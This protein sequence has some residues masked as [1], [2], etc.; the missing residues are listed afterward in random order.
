LDQNLE[1]NFGGARAHLSGAYQVER[2]RTGRGK[3]GSRLLDLV[4][5]SDRQ[6]VTTGTPDSTNIVNVVVDGV[7]HGLENA[8]D[9]PIIFGRNKSV[10]KEFKLVTKSILDLRRRDASAAVRVNVDSDVAEFSGTFDVAGAQRCRGRG[11]PCRLDL[12]EVGTGRSLTLWS[13][14]HSGAIRTIALAAA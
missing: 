14:R 4:R 8:S 9:L 7:R 10:S 12:T 5:L 6:A 11:G 2:L 13:S 1:V 3:G